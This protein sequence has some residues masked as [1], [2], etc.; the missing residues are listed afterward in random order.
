MLWQPWF[1]SRGVTDAG[2]GLCLTVSRRLITD[3]CVP[4]PCFARRAVRLV[5]TQVKLAV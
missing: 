1:T 3:H 5:P 4:Q 2:C